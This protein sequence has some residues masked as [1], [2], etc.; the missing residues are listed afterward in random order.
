MKHWDAALS[1][2]QQASPKIKQSLL[3]ACVDVVFV[4]GMLNEHEMEALRAIAD[5]MD[6]P[7][8]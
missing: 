3:K 6:C 5:A 2:L 8:P 1:Q 7:M 4:D